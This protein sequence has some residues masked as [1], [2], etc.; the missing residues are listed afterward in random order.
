MN[1]QSQMSKTEM[2][3]AL[4]LKFCAKIFKPD[5]PFFQRLASIWDLEA[6]LEE[7]LS[8]LI[9]EAQKTKNPMLI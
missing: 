1:T 2:M 3:E 4:N 7:S 6:D 5:S 9:P 8:L